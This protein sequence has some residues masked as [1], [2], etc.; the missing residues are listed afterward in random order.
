MSQDQEK[1][2]NEELPP[3][4]LPNLQM[5]ALLG[6][7]R[8]MMRVE[9]E[10]IHERLDRVEEGTQRG[11]PPFAP[12][13]PRRNRLRQREIDEVGEFEGDDFEEEFDRMSV[14]CHRRYGRD[15]EARNRMDNNLGSIKM[16]IPAFQGKSDPEAYLEW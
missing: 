11:Q 4:N 9:L 15:R 2:T 16:K 13:A 14:G 6:E 3:T 7:M 1:N 12:N 10:H 5:Q 8:R